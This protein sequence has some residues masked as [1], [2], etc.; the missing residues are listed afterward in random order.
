MR[1][2][3]RRESGDSSLDSDEPSPKRKDAKRVITNGLTEPAPFHNDLL[4][5][6]L[7]PAYKEPQLTIEEAKEGTEGN[8]KVCSYW[9]LHFKCSGA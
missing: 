3:L 4:A 1:K 7:L 8:F 9:M 5:Q 6:N 2:R